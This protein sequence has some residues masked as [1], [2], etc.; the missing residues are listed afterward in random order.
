MV[1]TCLR[2]PEFPMLHPD[3][4]GLADYGSTLKTSLERFVGPALLVYVRS[5]G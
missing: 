3:S 4:S 5:S 1:K 2:G